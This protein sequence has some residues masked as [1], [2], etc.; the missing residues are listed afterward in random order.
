MPL[1]ANMV[2][3]LAQWCA[4]SDILAD[5]RSKARGDFFG[6]DEP[7]TIKY[8]VGTGEVNGRERRFLG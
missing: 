3:E 1:T 7:G 2:E 8:M 6:Y 5:V 4:G